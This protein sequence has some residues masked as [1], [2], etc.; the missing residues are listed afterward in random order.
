MSPFPESK[1]ERPGKAETQQFFSTP[2]REE[3]EIESVLTRVT[4]T[5]GTAWLK[6]DCCVSWETM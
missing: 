6:R 2:D 3:R 5:H 4:S 1:E